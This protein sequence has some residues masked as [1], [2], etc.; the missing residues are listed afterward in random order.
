MSSFT[1]YYHCEHCK[2]TQD[3]CTESH[4]RPCGGVDCRGKYAWK[5]VTT[6]LDGAKNKTTIHS[7]PPNE[8]KVDPR[9]DIFT[10]DCW[11]VECT[12]ACSM[13]KCW[14]ENDD[15]EEELVPLGVFIDGKPFEEYVENRVEANS[16][17]V[18]DKM[19]NRLNEQGPAKVENDPVN[20][21]KHY[22]SHPSGV[23]CITITEHYNFNLGNCIKYLWRS[24]LKDSPVEDLEKAAWYLQREI[25][26]RKAKASA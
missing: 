18:A 14:F 17:L 20:H 23:E 13:D 24:D 8:I 21:P 1:Y 7:P 5:T 22:T 19:A 15:E 11:E 16:L 25:N 12:E 6:S 2:P 9:K 26:T 4:F 10:P 3:S